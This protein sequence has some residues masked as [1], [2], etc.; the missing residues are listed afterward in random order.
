MKKIIYILIVLVGFSACEEDFLDPKYT[1]DLDLDQVLDDPA[2]VEAILLKA[3]EGI[4]SVQDNYGGFLDCATQN[5]VTNVTS[6]TLN[7]TVANAW[8]AETNPL[9]RWLSSYASIQSINTF[10]EIGLRGDIIWKRS[11]DEDNERIAERLEGEAYFLRGY[12]Y[13]E[14]LKR[15]AGVD[16][17]GVLMGVPIITN[18]LSSDD[19][20][21]L[22]RNT[23]QEVIDFIVDDLEYASQYLPEEY[24]GDTDAVLGVSQLGRATSVACDALLSRVLLYA[25]SELNN[26]ADAITLNQE[27]ARAAARAIDVF[28][29]L[30]DVYNAAGG[31]YDAYFNS[32]QDQETIMR[33]VSGNSNALEGINF[34]PSLFGNGR[35]NPT[36]NLVDAFPM[37]D[38]YPIDHASSSYDPTLPYE[39]RDNRFYMTVLYNG[40][41]MKS[42]VVETFNGGVDTPS[43]TDGVANN[44]NSTRTG[45]YLRKWLSGEADRNPA[46]WVTALHYFT[47]IRKGEVYLNF[48]EAANEAFGPDSDPFGVGLTA[49]DAIREVR[50]RAGIN[51]PDLY[52]DEVASDQDALRELIK[53]ERRV[54]LC[55]EGHY[56]YDIRRWNEDLNEP[57]MGMEIEEDEFGVAQYTP[58]EIHVPQYQSHM[59][60][61]PMPYNEVIKT[62]SISQNSG[63]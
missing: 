26:S 20:P 25:G 40:A 35:T 5:A 11:N 54:E 8:L 61:G 7:R 46:N 55:F 14:L 27:A 32:G 28:G 1:N 21:A 36:Q 23:Y 45:Y 58:F 29:T 53:N 42:H 60:Y 51:Q 12:H 22:S 18:S 50:R 30:P 31:N 3:Y 24:T 56:F 4:P 59:T 9:D 17:S 34:P 10:I 49:V 44:T 47:V 2:K 62:P 37:A 6:T 33:R 57:V 15:F 19:V 13:F 43:G 41:F 52:L 39:N 16:D 38:G 48:A 63:W